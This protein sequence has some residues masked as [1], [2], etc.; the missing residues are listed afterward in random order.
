MKNA[1]RRITLAAM[2]MGLVAGAG[3]E[4]ARADIVLDHSQGLRTR[5]RRDLSQYTQ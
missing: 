4:R 1:T 5:F 3:V 2:M